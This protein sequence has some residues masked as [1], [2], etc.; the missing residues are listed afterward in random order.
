MSQ[1][2]SSITDEISNGKNKQEVRCR[3]CNSLM[4]KE[5]E[6]SY[7]S[8]PFDLPLMHQK[9][10]KDINTIECESLSDYWIIND[11]FTFENI[12][13]SNT[14]DKRKFLICADCDM[15]PVGYHDIDT[16]KCYLALKRVHHGKEP[17][18]K[19]VTNNS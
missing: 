4:L 1:D 11:M 15:G 3:F 19:A 6:G 17:A 14:V 5:Q 8:K 18:A 12:G 9:N 16:K 2:S 7:E 13:F 10:T